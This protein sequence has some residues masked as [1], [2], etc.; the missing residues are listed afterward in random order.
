MKYFFSFTKKHIQ[1]FT[2]LETL[3][4]ITIL[5]LV[6]TGPLAVIINSSSYARHAKDSMVANYL[7]EE[8]VEL[9][10]NQYDSIYT[11]CK[12]QSEDAFCTPVGSEVSAGKIAWRLFKDRFSDQGALHP[13]CFIKTDAG[14]PENPSGCSFD[15]IDMLSPASTTPTRY[16]ASDASSVTNCAFVVPVNKNLSGGRI[17]RTFVCA[18]VP[19]HKTGSIAGKYYTR[20]VLLEDILSYETGSRLERY[21]DDIRITVLVG[22]RG[23][24]GRYQVATT[25]RFMHAQP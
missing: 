4:A 16:N 10:Q 11:Y 1:A 18:N 21:E 22:Y 13:S 17:A 5:A 9:M 19:S 15:F 14:A 6:I 3:V 12:K 25:T 20:A 23:A 7:A 8:A 2:L 24:N